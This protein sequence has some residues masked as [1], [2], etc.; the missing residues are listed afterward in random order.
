MNRHHFRSGCFPCTVSSSLI[1]KME[2]HETLQAKGALVEWS[3]GMGD[4]L[5]CSHTWLKDG[6]PPPSPI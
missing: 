4:I 2:P 6:H 3:P 5:F 1:D